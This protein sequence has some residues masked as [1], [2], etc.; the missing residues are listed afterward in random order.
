MIK[1]LS[2]ILQLAITTRVI[3]FVSDGELTITNPEMCAEG[4]KI[5]HAYISILAR[6]NR[7]VLISC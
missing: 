5:I 4:G 3:R 6:R 2:S 7:W 1:H